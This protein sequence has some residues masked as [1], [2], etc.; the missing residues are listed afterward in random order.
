MAEQNPV[1]QEDVAQRAGVSRSVVSYVLNNGPRKVS[2]AT[3]QR[4][5]DAINELEY[6]PNEFAQ[7]LKQ[8]SDAVQNTI[9]IVT[10]GK[11]YNLIERPYYNI[12]LSGLYDYA[13]QQN[14]QIGFLAYWDALRDPIFFNKHVHEYE[15]SS[16]ILIL[17]SLIPDHQEDRALLEQIIAR[18]PNIVCLE[19]TVLDLPTVMFD[20]AEAA[21][22]AVNHLIGLG[23][24]RIA[25]VGIN[26]QRETG[27]KQ[28]LL[29]NNLLYDPRLVDFL[30]PSAAPVQS[31]YNM[32]A[33][34]LQQDVDF[35][36]IFTAT[37][38]AAIGAI[39]ALKDHGLR[40]PE[41]IA[42]ASM[43]NIELASMVRPALT[44]VDIPKRTLARF[45]IQSLQTQKEF[46]DQNQV[47]MMLPT[48]LIVRESCGGN[49]NP[50]Q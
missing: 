29:E 37:D 43:D 13:Y 49:K 7:R 23:H 9:G 50:R 17:P 5:L 6:R 45:A 28:A 2:E 40:V 3:R 48:R 26:D 24:Q 16:L 46:P 30:E 8:G 22:Y 36:A 33:R 41:D 21:R 12:I 47:S 44:T 20:R 18:I 11:G 35:T 27:H 42:V 4:V 38:E 10:G 1:T 14:Q 32:I 15:I 25:F 39:A 19:E 34:F 31:A